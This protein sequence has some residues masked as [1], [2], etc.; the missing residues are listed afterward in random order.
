MRVL[1]VVSLATVLVLAF[2][3]CGGPPPT[4]EELAATATAGARVEPE[5]ADA[6]ATAEAK[7]KAEKAAK[8]F[9]DREE[10]RKGFHCLSAWDGNHDGLEKL[11]RDRLN[12]PGSMKTYETRITPVD[13]DERGTGHYITVDFGARNS[14][15]GMVRTN[16]YGWVD[17]E[18]CEAILLDI[19]E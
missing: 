18:T 8:A 10:R 19:G 15:G 17:H 4:E 2:A 9:E 3:S 7:A 1:I 12:D 6:T 11:V 14:F 16:A 13:T 5:K